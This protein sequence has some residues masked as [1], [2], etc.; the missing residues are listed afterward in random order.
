MTKSITSDK[1]VIINTAMMMHECGEMKQEKVHDTHISYVDPL[2]VCVNVRASD[3]A[4]EEREDYWEWGKGK[5][6]EN[7][8]SINEG[9]RAIG[10]MQL[11][12]YR[13]IAHIQKMVGRYGTELSNGKTKA[14]VECDDKADEEEAV[15]KN[16]HHVLRVYVYS[17]S[18]EIHVYMKRFI[19]NYREQRMKMRPSRHRSKR[20]CSALNARLASNENRV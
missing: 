16:V 11:Y 12:R 4:R 18:K 1:F 7:N 19:V 6:E 8:E 14:D 10:W 9:M 3:V 17:R 2:L 13:T 15:D 20:F 5:R